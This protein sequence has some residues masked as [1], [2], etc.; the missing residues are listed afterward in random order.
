MRYKLKATCTTTATIKTLFYF[1][2][3][4]VLRNGEE[5]T[6]IEVPLPEVPLLNDEE[7]IQIILDDPTGAPAKLSR[8]RSCSVRIRHDH[9]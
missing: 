3:K 7:I 2:G 8:N 5:Q 6:V 9:G 4:A 1:T